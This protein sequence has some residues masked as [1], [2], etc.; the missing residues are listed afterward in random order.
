MMQKYFFDQARGQV[1]GRFHEL[2]QPGQNDPPRHLLCSIEEYEF[3]PTGKRRSEKE[4]AN[5]LVQKYESK[6]AELREKSET[7]TREEKIKQKG[8]GI[9]QLMQQW[10]DNEVSPTCKPITTREYLRTCHLYINFV[11]NHPVRD[12]KKHHATKFQT[13]LQNHGLSEAG[14]RKHQTQLGIFLN[15]AYSEEHLDKPVKLKKIRPVHKGPVIYAPDDLERLKISI[16]K[17]I[18]NA[19]SAY[20]KKCSTNHLRVFMAF[21]HAV[22]RNGEILA[23]PLRNILLEDQEILI[24]EVP[25]IHWKPKTRQERVIPMNPELQEFLQND[26]KN[27]NTDEFWYLDDGAG[28]LAYSSNSHLSQAMRRKLKRLGLDQKGLKPLHSGRSS[29]IT[30]MLAAG[31]KPDFVS[32]LAGH[33]N[34]QTTLDYY[35]R[36]ENYDLRDTVGLLSTEPKK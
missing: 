11:G 25:E 23:L 22:L 35:V 36:P 32:R 12:F 1:K 34:L 3:R 2:K 5:F 15:W 16:E 6:L 20:Q 33:R 31:G 10:I 26:L 4:K 13:G 30:G 19:P 29:G 14:I 18:E 21:R 7:R 8:P 28:A 9:N 24:T 27:R 17:A